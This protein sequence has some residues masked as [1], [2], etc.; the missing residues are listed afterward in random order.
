MKSIVKGKPNLEIALKYAKHYGIDLS[1]IHDLF[2][3]NNWKV[4]R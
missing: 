1:L 2:D 4:V 3:E